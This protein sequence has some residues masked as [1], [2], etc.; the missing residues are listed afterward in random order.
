MLP[1][2]PNITI[3]TFSWNCISDELVAG[4]NPGRSE[5]APTLSSVETQF[6]TDGAEGMKLGKRANIN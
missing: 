6:G 1:L 5:G 4:N 2:P 3:P